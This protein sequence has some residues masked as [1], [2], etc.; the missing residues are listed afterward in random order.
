MALS[1]S[2]TVSL[3]VDVYVVVFVPSPTVIVPLAMIPSV[4]N[5]VFAV[6][7]TVPV[8]TAGAATVAEELVVPLEVED[9]EDEDD[10]L[11]DGDV[12][13]DEDVSPV[14]LEP[15]LMELSALCTAAE[16]WVFTRLRAAWL[17]RLAKPLDSVVDAPNMELMTES[18]C[19]VEDASLDAWFQ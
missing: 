14:L 7:G 18:V 11:D 19:A 17:A 16:S 13:D 3:P 10:V 12:L 8:P 4:N 5:E 15:P 2:P 1:R 6:S 9:E